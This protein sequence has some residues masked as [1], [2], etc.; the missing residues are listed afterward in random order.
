MAILN[1]DYPRNWPQ[2][3]WQVCPL[4]VSKQKDRQDRQEGHRQDWVTVFHAI[5]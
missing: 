4:S 3:G 1:K 2:P 5:T